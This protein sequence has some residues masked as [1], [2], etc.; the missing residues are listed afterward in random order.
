MNHFFLHY[1]RFS[2][3][4]ENVLLKVERIIPDILR[5]TE[6]NIT[7]TLPHGDPRFSAE[8]NT[9]IPNLSIDYNLSTKK[10]EPTLFTETCFIS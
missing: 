8:L 10:F 3:E 6:T 1:P 2:D 4:K 5:K 9:N 7:S